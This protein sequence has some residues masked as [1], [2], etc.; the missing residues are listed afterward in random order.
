MKTSSSILTFSFGHFL[1][2]FSC[3]WLL[4]SMN[5]AGQL[6]LTDA[7]R[8]ILLFNLLA[9]G[10][11]F[12]FG[13]AADRFALNGRF[14]AAGG[15][16]AVAAALAVGGHSPVAAVLLAGLGSAAFHVGG[17]IDAVTREAGF[18]RAGIFVSTGV[19]GIALG[20]HFGEEQKIPVFFLIGLLIFTALAAVSLCTGTRRETQNLSYREDDDDASAPVFSSVGMAVTLLL[21]AILIRAWA[22]FL[23]PNAG[24][25]SRFAFAIPAAAAFAGMFLGGVLADLFGAR[26][27]GTL[28]VLISIPLF[29]A[30]AE[31]F[32]VFA[33]AIFFFNAAMPVTLVELVRRLKG[34]EGLA[35]G[36]TEL[37]ALCGYLGSTLLPLSDRPA[38][39]AVVFL[40]LIAAADIYLTASDR[41]E[42]LLKK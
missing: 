22:G 7:A 8:I 24:S 9:F 6:E 38:K 20:A 17:G 36:L 28:A 29:F 34:R 11:Q 3:G 12:L 16:A 39:F 25:E 42:G 10:T 4:C 23:A 18:T 1:T 19:P 35:F 21:G 37:A 14:F 30:G 41:G 40:A 33:A 5:A 32:L 31:H 27:V 13:L 15:C 26:K 2:D